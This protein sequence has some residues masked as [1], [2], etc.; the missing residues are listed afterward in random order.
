MGDKK[1]NDYLL[2]SGAYE[3][4]KW[5]GLIALPAI[6]VFVSAVG[7]AWGWPSTE[8]TVLTLNSLG[9]LIGALVGVSQ[10]SGSNSTKEGGDNDD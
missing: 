5:L 3:F 8:A 4:L 1:D 6:A 9:V 7:P 2:P 10:A